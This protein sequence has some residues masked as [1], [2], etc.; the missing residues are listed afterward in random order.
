MRLSAIPAILLIVPITGLAAGAPGPSLTSGPCGFAHDS[1]L[2]RGPALTQAA[3][4]MRTVGRWGQVSAQPADLPPVLRQLID[5]PLGDWKGRLRQHLAGLGLSEASVG[6]SLDVPVS[7][8]KGRATSARYFVIHD[9]SWPRIG[10][11]DFPPESDAHLND[12]S[13]YAHPSTALAHVFVNRMG[14]PWTAHGFDEPW[15]ATK[16]ETRVVGEPA[17]GLFLHVELVQPRKPHPDGAPGNDALAPSPGFTPAQYDTLALLYLAASVRAG[18]GL[19]PALHGAVDEGIPDGHDD[20]QH[21]ELQAFGDALTTLSARLQ[22]QA[23]P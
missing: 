17:K 4:L 19:V 6:G 13:A 14:Q 12:L 20:P 18:K 8:V 2:F 21:F 5:Q 1:L 23:A 16:L 10:T 3:C 9:T 15:R 22:A 11:G 7:A